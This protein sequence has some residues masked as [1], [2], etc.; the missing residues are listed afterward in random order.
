[1]KK[2]ITKNMT[3]R[4]VLEIHEETI[5]VLRKHLGNC[6]GCPSAHLETIAL[7]AHLHEK[8]AD[9]IVRELNE[10]INTKSKKQNKKQKTKNKNKKGD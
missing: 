7:G 9:E 1:M 4:E 3:I 8:D 6:V 10:I 2:K 5:V